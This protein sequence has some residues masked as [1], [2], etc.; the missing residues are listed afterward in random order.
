MMEVDEGYSRPRTP[1]SGKQV[2]H[3]FGQK[4]LR[5][6]SL[7]PYMC[8]LGNFEPLQLPKY[9]VLYNNV[10]MKNIMYHIPF[11]LM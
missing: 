6:F 4:Y 11:L 7:W 1:S 8:N 2:K 10:N 5:V 3:W 9:V